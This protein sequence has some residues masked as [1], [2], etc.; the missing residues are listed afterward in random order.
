MEEE[1]EDLDTPGYFRGDRVTRRRDVGDFQ[2]FVRPSWLALEEPP[3]PERF[4]SVGGTLRFSTRPRD[5]VQNGEI[6]RYKS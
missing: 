3:G 1:G 4:H 5:R 6:P 2:L